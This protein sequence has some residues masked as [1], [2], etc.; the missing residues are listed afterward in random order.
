VRVRTYP[1]TYRAINHTVEFDGISPHESVAGD[2]DEE[3]E[4]QAIRWKPNDKGDSERRMPADYIMRRDSNAQR[5]Y[6]EMRTNLV[7]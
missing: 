2:T 1:N 3:A 4:F 7:A 6:L 5:A